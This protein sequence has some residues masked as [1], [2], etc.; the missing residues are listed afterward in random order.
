ML[1]HFG[2]E[3]SVTESG[4]KT[5]ITVK[6]EAELVGRDVT[7]PAD[8]SSA[9]FLAAAAAL[10][11]GSDITSRA[12]WSIRPAPDSTRCCG[13]WAPTSLSLDEREEGGEPVADIRVRYA[14]LDRRASAGRT[15]RPA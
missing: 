5:R 13:K 12:C 7:V 14:T 2:A 9:A 10:V 4:G 1:R 11:P 15:A 8:P 3:V 6:G